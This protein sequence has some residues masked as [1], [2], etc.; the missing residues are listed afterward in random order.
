MFFGGYHGFIWNP[1]TLDYGVHRLPRGLQ[2]IL[3]EN[4]TALRIYSVS[5]MSAILPDVTLLKGPDEEQP[6]CVLDA[7]PRHAINAIF[8]TLAWNSV[9]AVSS[10]NSSNHTHALRDCCMF[11]CVVY[12]YD[13]SLET[14]WW[15][16]IDGVCMWVKDTFLLFVW[17]FVCIAEPQVCAC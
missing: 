9:P 14:V 17:V 13:Y 6:C 3:V 15:R 12:L 16:H 2:C 4:W 1:D 8:G 5:C 10:H 7:G 11:L